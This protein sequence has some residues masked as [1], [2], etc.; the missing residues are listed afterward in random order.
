[1]AEPL[2]FDSD[3][4]HDEGSPEILGPTPPRPKHLA[5]N[6]ARRLEP[7]FDS[8]LFGSGTSR[9]SAGKSS[10][11]SAY[12]SPSVSETN[13]QSDS[14]LSSSKSPG[15]DLTNLV[16]AELQ[17]SN[18]H[19]KVLTSRMDCIEK[20]LKSLEDSDHHDADDEGDGPSKPKK[21]KRKHSGPSKEIRVSCQCAS[22]HMGI[23]KK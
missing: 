20:R 11:R 10:T 16:L 3:C 14:G 9:S 6:S 13:D 21:R 19:L 17:E 7:E 22:I 4:T 15:T 1:M 8:I 18:Q 23:C 5:R 2:A 12:R